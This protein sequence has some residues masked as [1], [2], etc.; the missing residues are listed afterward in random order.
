MGLH[1]EGVRGAKT[2]LVNIVMTHFDS[3]L[4]VQKRLFQ[5]LFW[6]IKAASRHKFNRGDFHYLLRTHWQP[7]RVHDFFEDN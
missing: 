5:I 4:Q 6:K 7:A 1:L 2:V 3:P